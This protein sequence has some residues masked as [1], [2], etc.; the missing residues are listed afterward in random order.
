MAWVWEPGVA[1]RALTTHMNAHTVWRRPVL[2]PASFHMRWLAMYAVIQRKPLSETGRRRS[3]CRDSTG[4]ATC[5]M[6][7]WVPNRRNSGL[8][9]G[10]MTLYTPCAQVKKK[11]KER[12]GRRMREMKFKWFCH[13]IDGHGSNLS[14][15]CFLCIVTGWLSGTFPG[16]QASSSTRGRHWGNINASGSYFH[17]CT[18]AA[19]AKPSHSASSSSISCTRLDR[20]P[21]KC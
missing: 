6:N 18:V 9:A 20:Y 12:S 13:T 7:Q 16:R 2:Y 5:W 4:S 11:L 14:R 15:Y 17:L 10:Y 19:V 3:W 8:A 1:H 21:A